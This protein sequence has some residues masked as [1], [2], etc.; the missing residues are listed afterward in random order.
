[1]R[2]LP[3]SLR[4]W[5]GA[6]AGLAA[7]VVL[8]LGVRY[9]G[10]GGPGRVDRWVVPPTADS[11]RGVWRGVALGVD[12]LGEPVGSVGVVGVLVAGCL[13]RRGVR[14][15][16][17]AVVAPGVTVVVTTVLKHVVGRTIHG[18]G[19]LSYPSGHTAFAT[20]VTVAAGVLAVGRLG[21]GRVAGTLLVLAA[22]LTAGSV[23]G[24]AEVALGAH[25]ATDAVG[26]WCTALALTPV[27][28]WLIDASA[29]RLDD[30]P[31]P[32]LP[33]PSSQGAPPL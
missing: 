5:L 8:V 9:A 32:P 11:V 12:F 31:P 2:L 21:L 23:M 16:V 3:P 27:T 20:T 14:A 18:D 33:V 13:W 29:G 25:Y 24:W 15:A 28:A 19:N 10:E 1:M 30:S 26:G 17:F 6:T 7:L 4:P 22:S